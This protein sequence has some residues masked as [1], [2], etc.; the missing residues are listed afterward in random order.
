LIFGSR[1]FIFGNICIFLGHA[2]VL[3]L[4]ILFSWLLF[5]SSLLKTLLFCVLFGAFGRGVDRLDLLFLCSLFLFGKLTKFL[6]KGTDADYSEKAITRTFKRGA[7]R[8]VKFVLLLIWPL[9]C[10]FDL[11]QSSQLGISVGSSVTRRWCHVMC[12]IFL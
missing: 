9:I 4:F 10:H 2:L 8:I 5:L 12:F 11:W 6:K 3:L 7:K 1:I